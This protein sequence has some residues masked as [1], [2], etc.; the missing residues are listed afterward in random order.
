MLSSWKTDLTIIVK[1]WSF[2][3]LFQGKL[4]SEL[5]LIFM[6]SFPYSPGLPFIFSIRFLIPFEISMYVVKTYLVLTVEAKLSFYFHFS[7][8]HSSTSAIIKY[9]EFTLRIPL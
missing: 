5:I 9:K 3:V 2:S 7:S 8:M 4:S 6:K 1:L